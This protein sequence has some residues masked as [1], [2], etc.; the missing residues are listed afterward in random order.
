MKHMI[1]T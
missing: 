1:T